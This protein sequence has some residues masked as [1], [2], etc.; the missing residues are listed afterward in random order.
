MLDGKTLESKSIDGLVEE[1]QTAI[2]QGHRSRSTTCGAHLPGWR[3]CRD[4]LTTRSSPYAGFVAGLP[5]PRSTC[6]TSARPR[7]ASSPSLRPGTRA[8]VPA[9]LDALREF[10]TFR[11]FAHFV[12]VYLA[13]VDLLR[14]P[15]D[16]R[17]LTYEVAADM[18]AQNI[19]YAELTLTP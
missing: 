19:R 10:Y 9:D 16:I 5:R 7:R 4:D 13:V 3:A 1:V 8:T 18:A 6:T 17:L 12:E 11:D 2:D 14:E 15:E